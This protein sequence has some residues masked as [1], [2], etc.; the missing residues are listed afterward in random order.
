MGTN[1]YAFLLKVMLVLHLQ[2]PCTIMGIPDTTPYYYW[3]LINT[4]PQQ[5]FGVLLRIALGDLITAV[6]RYWSLRK[7]H[8]QDKKAPRGKYVKIQGKRYF[9]NKNHTV[10]NT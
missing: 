9:D 8:P 6:P 3:C 1:Q 2:L 7:L 10:V 5:D 4:L